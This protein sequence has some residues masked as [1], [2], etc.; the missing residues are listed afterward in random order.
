MAGRKRGNR[1]PSVF[2]KTGRGTARPEG[3]DW[4]GWGA[5]RVPGGKRGSCEQGE[6]RRVAGGARRRSFGQGPQGRMK[7]LGKRE[8]DSDQCVRKKRLCVTG[9]D[10]G[11]VRVGGRGG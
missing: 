9:E 8:Y 2:G 1:D 5:N 11:H 10:P 4:P 7:K 6:N 3:E